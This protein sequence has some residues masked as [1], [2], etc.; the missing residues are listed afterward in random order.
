MLELWRP[1]LGRQ[2]VEGIDR[3][4]LRR[5]GIMILT[6][7]IGATEMTN[8]SCICVISIRELLFRE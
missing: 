8:Y 6:P 3:A 2:R 7:E 5:D 1:S 4:G